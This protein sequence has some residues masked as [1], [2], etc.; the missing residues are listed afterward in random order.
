MHLVVEKYFSPS[1]ACENNSNTFFLISHKC[2]SLRL[3]KC[4]VP[5]FTWED[6]F[7]LAQVVIASLRVARYDKGKPTIRNRDLPL[8]YTGS[9]LSMPYTTATIGKQFNAMSISL[10]YDKT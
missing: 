6:L 8:R 10:L 4:L 5:L 2:V 1:H 3:E 7:S 9:A